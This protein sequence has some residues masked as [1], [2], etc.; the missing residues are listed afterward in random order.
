M[1]KER[2]MLSQKLSLYPENPHRNR[3]YSHTMRF[4]SRPDAGGDYVQDPS[5]FGAGKE[6][7]GLV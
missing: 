6:G 7:R 5:L 3:T 1:T 4:L 2:R